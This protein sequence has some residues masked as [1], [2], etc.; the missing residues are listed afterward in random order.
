MLSRHGWTKDSFKYGDQVTVEA[1]PHKDRSI[2]FAWPTKLTKQ[3]G[4]VLINAT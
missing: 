2:K 4:T 1:Y 3:D